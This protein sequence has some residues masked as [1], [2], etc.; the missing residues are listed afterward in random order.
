[1]SKREDYSHVVDFKILL[2][3]YIDNSVNERSFV[4]LDKTFFTNNFSRSD[5]LNNEN[6]NDVEEE[7][8]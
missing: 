2:N 1:M 6:L 5:R 4:C 8:V 3:H 7:K